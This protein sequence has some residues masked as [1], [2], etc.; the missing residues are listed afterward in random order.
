[1]SERDVFGR[2]AVAVLT[3][4]EAAAADREARER[5]G[6]PERLLMENAGRSAAQI[7]DRLFPR[8]RV[9]AVVGSGHNGG[10]GLVLLR[11][12]RA[13]GRE[14][15]YL[16]AGSR[17]PDLALAHGHELPT[18]DLGIESSSAFD[19]TADL[20]RTLSGADILVDALLGTGASG[21]PRGQAAAA[22]EAMNASGRPV[23][24]LDLPSGV[25][26]TTGAVPGAA[27][28]AT[29]TVTFGWPKQGLLF[30]PARSYCGRLI[31]VEIGFP[32]LSMA[33]AAGSGRIA[34]GSG[35]EAPG[36]GLVVP[37]SELITPGWATLRLPARPP[38]AYKS[39]AGRL[40]VVAGREGMAGAALVAAEAAL[41]AG[42]GYLWLASVP[43]NR[44][45]LQAAL[46]EAIFIDRTDQGALRDAAASADAVLIGPGIGVDDA[47]RELLAGLLEAMAGKPALLDA[48]AL[49][50]LGR[51]E[52]ALRSAASGRA[53][54]L[55]PHPGEMSRLTGLE[56]AEIVA[57][58]VGVARDFAERIGCVTLLKGMPSVV[59]APAA[60]VLINT[61][62]SSDLARAGM[63][64]QLAGV[65]AA[66]LAA[67]GAVRGAT[68]SVPHAAA[69]STARD[70]AGLGLFYAGR[71]ADLAARGRSLSPRDLSGHLG[72]AFRSPGPADPPIGLPFITF[73]QPARW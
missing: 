49:T 64:D 24:A 46:P 3:A 50:L 38:D 39:T 15:A 29:T 52:A 18:L 57:D 19:D 28:R 13:W 54:V 12:L 31:A 63:G 30:Q 51:D 32:P 6:I 37:G 44:V 27:V 14:V 68:E 73:D 70:A 58:P 23:V 36:A 42:A 20:A 40:L 47:A 65:I 67:L 16:P 43:E 9:V 53:L 21:A 35:P 10:D 60:P 22:I 45:P 33:R 17:N 69:I 26:A 66:F 7:V 4:G 8:G 59:A 56:V 11:N 5:G 55:T 34:A 62:G 2:P 41:R 72:L 25:D 71:A 1:L 48:D 61:V